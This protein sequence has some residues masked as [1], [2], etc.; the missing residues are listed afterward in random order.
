MPKGEKMPENLVP[1]NKKNFIVSLYKFLR[2]ELLKLLK[3]KGFIDLYRERK[4]SLRQKK[5]KDSTIYYWKNDSS[6]L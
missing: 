1:V 6:V 5:S 2:K 4:P 3:S